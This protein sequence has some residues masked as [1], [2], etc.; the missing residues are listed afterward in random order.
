MTKLKK[1]TDIVQ[2][3]PRLVIMF[4][5]DGDRE[6]FQWGTVGDIPILTLIGYISRVQAEL[7]LLEPGDERRDCPESALVIVW[8]RE[9]NRLNWF[10]HP[11]V[12]ADSTVGML[13]LIKATIVGTH[14]ARHVA[15]QQVI[16]GPD[17]Q[18]A[19]R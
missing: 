2:D 15:A 14:L 1:F 6:L 12:P 8:D 13:E 19:R 3:T 4:K 7:P 17:G 11:D 5:R 10:V 9:N 16:L 18:P